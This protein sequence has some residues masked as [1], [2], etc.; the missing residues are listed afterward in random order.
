MLND[1]G[2]KSFT[3]FLTS[4]SARGIN[5]LP[6]IIR[7]AARAPAFIILPSSISLLSHENCKQN[8]WMNQTQTNDVY[9]RQFYSS[10]LSLNVPKP[11]SFPF[12]IIN[13]FDTV[14]T[15]SPSLSPP[16]SPATN[17]SCLSEECSS[18]VFLVFDYICF[19][20]LLWQ[21]GL[22]DKTSQNKE[23]TAL[24]KESP[25]DLDVTVRTQ[26][27]WSNSASKNNFKKVTNYLFV[28]TVTLSYTDAFH[29]F[30]WRCTESD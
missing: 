13:V 19:R 7:T 5:I 22:K 16:S 21:L 20:F 23:L 28:F 18:Q 9:W 29:V 26:N 11:L 17:E 3:R 4:I 24:E 6:L 15:L 2:S 25:A 27:G 12:Y 1:R 30:I 8:A 10:C 14:L